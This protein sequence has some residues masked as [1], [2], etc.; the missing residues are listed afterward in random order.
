MNIKE[1]YIFSDSITSICIME[2]KI[3]HIE[4][5]QFFVIKLYFNKVVSLFLKKEIKKKNAKVFYL[6]LNPGRKKVVGSNKHEE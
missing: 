3:T 4:Y 1:R 5:V 6:S 2:L